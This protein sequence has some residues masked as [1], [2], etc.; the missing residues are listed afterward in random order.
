MRSGTFRIYLLGEPRFE[1]DG[2][3]H[4]FSAPPKTL[5]LLAYLLMHRHA[6]ISRE[7]LAGAL[8][9]EARAADAFANLRRHLQYLDKTLPPAAEQQ[10][11]I[12]ATRKTLLW[13]AQSA[14]WL[15]VELFETE[16]RDAA[17]RSHAVRL[18]AGDLCAGSDE[19][20]L[21]F[22][23]ERLRTLQ[24][25]NLASLCAQAR[26]RGQFVE[27][28]QYA[29][30][31]LALDPWREDALRMILEM[32]ALL[33]DRAGAIAQY[34]TFVE[35][36]AN[37][38]GVDPSEETIDLYERLRGSPG[39]PAE[40]FAPLPYRERQPLIGRS[41]ELATLREQWM[42]ATQGHAKLVLIGGDAGIGK[43]A[44]LENL[45][46]I[47]IADGGRVLR[48]ASGTDEGAPYQ[49]LAQALR[50]EMPVESYLTEFS[51]DGDRLRLFEKFAELLSACEARTPVLVAM[52]DLH[53]AGNASVELLRYLVMRLTRSRVL[54]AGTYRE[55]EVHRGHP[56]R[57][58]RRQLNGSGRLVNVALS[59]LNVDDVA[60]LAKSRV[61]R[62]LDA[63]LV[64]RIHE[65]TGG[66]PLFV[67]E[68]LHH[69]MEAGTE[70]IPQSVL[71]IVDQRLQ[72]LSEDALVTVEACAIAGDGVSAEVLSEITGLC[73]ADVTAALDVLVR[74]HILRQAAGSDS[75]AFV[76]EIIRSGVYE[77]IPSSR[78]RH[79]HA[80]MARILRELHGDHFSGIAASVGRHSE[81]GGLSGE[82]A[83]AYAAAADAAAAVYGLSEA[84]HY[85]E[86]AL[87]LAHS[88][89]QRFRA[90]R[91]L[92]SV[93]GS[94][95]LREEQRAHVTAMRGIARG[96]SI[97]EQGEALCIELDLLAAAGGANEQRALEELKR[98]AETEPYFA[99]AYSLRAG[100]RCARDGELKQA[101][102]ALRAAVE[103]FRDAGDRE[104]ALRAYSALIEVCLDSG[105]PA[106][107]LLAEARS[108]LGGES[109][110]RLEARLANVRTKALVKIRPLEAY[111]AA[112]EMLRCAKLAGDVWLE[113]QAYGALGR[114]AAVVGRMDEA[115]AQLRTCAELCAI[116]GAGADLVRTLNWQG[117][118]ELRVA[119][120][121]SA[122]VFAGEAARL[123]RSQRM[124]VE[125]VQALS[126]LG[127]AWLYAGELESGTEHLQNALTLIEAH[128]LAGLRAGVI[129]CLGETKIWKGDLKGG[130]ALLEES[131][132]LVRE[133]GDTDAELAYSIPLAMAYVAAGRVHQAQPAAAA[134]SDQLERIAAFRFHPQAI[135]WAAAHLLR[136]VGRQNEAEAFARRAYE[137]YVQA[138]A[139]IRDPQSRAAFERY[140]YNGLLIGTHERG[141]WIDDPVR[142]WFVP[143]SRWETQAV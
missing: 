4:M 78:R 23:R 87:Q 119:N 124:I 72:R 24:L 125:E 129:N 135:L 100:S 131:I 44:L 98:L 64:Q 84:E 30:L 73:E 85:A 94:R 90:L 76:H 41:N 139:S 67:V 34:E 53:W 80:R 51:E 68:L 92:A 63:A 11:W 141:E 102:E 21:F 69:I 101:R 106:D 18:Y 46:D 57:A 95:A 77:R 17:R 93:A 38:L 105:D 58:L 29:Q 121:E 35:N 79:A 61:S 103:G 10:P 16:S 97:R 43:S 31:I 96:L 40:L 99:A 9:P 13:N 42:R 20:W 136:F 123:A 75:F 110:A 15:D 6:P 132:A 14:Y 70:S 117:I 142:A 126:T 108:A 83:E 2:A 89:E 112:G 25:A 74:R 138:Y 52:E 49:V 62:P 107:T 47:A 8:W 22:D 137:T 7:A 50:E 36:L 33:G 56:L 114:A 19:E 59:A 3:T 127:A 134:I 118:A 128:G 60:E 140:A 86:K 12:E 26:E 113:T 65:R 120:H 111:E 116:T 37:E 122:R 82:A 71:E 91:V 104:G 48:G 5:P 32:R 88:D 1:F 54:F 27:A 45:A 130:T 39:A 143:P 109:D 28:S 55:G 81:L 115:R 66:N 133:Q